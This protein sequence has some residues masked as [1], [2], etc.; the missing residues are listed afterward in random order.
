M[1]WYR[2]QIINSRSKKQTGSSGTGLKD[3]RRGL[4]HTDY[5]PVCIYHFCSVCYM[6]HP[7][8]RPLFYQPNNILWRV[9]IKKIMKIYNM[10]SP[11]NL[12]SLHPSYVQIFSSAPC[13]QTTLTY[14]RFS[15]AQ[16]VPKNPSNPEALCNVLQHVTTRPGVVSIPFNLRNGQPRSGYPRL[17]FRYIRG[18]VPSTYGGR[19]RHP[20]GSIF[21]CRS[22]HG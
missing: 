6:P 3:F 12:L 9:Q 20:Q 17:L 10:H 2:I 1:T 8:H 13:S 4:T 18:T 22:F 16:I 7:S 21:P 14:F 11:T 5:D 15:V 19:H